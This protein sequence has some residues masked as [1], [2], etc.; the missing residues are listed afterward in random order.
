VHGHPCINLF[1]LHVQ[2]HCAIADIVSAVPRPSCL[3][4]DIASRQT[5]TRHNIADKSQ[6]VTSDHG[7]HRLSSVIVN[8]TMK[9]QQVHATDI[10]V[11]MPPSG[12]EGLV[13][14]SPNSN[15]TRGSPL[16]RLGGSWSASLTDGPTQARFYLQR[17][18]RLEASASSP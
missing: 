10:I 8:A 4:S 2:I 12:C 7:Q 9:R 16:I 18:H 11:L 3:D 15:L 6:T 13:R 5:S 14:T 1:V 17:R